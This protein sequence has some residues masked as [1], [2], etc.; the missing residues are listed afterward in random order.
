[1]RPV[2]ALLAFLTCGV[3]LG[4]CSRLVHQS[5][6]DPRLAVFDFLRE[7]VAE[8]YVGKL[9]YYVENAAL[10]IGSAPLGV[11]PQI[12]E[13][14]ESILHSDGRIYDKTLKRQ[15][16]KFY[17]WDVSLD[18]AE[19]ANVKAAYYFGH[20]GGTEYEV[21]LHLYRGVW[22]VESSLVRVQS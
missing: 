2:I 22:E 8:G 12:R 17:I 1:M 15:G 4:A 6:A 19:K 21:V 18:G 7:K 13:L 11:R 14:T 9:D 16:V 5:A 3:L 10:Y 20:D